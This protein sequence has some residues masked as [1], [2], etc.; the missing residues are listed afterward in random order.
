MFEL[1]SREKLPFMTLKCDAK[2][3]KTDLWFVKWND[4]LADFH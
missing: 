1:K 3:R 2:W 4:E